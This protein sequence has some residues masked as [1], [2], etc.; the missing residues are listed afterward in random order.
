MMRKMTV[1]KILSGPH[2]FWVQKQE[3]DCSYFLLVVLTSMFLNIPLNF[4]IDEFEG[5]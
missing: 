5:L 1:E 4:F 2:L 3:N